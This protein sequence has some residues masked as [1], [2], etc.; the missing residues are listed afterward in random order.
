M[1]D[2]TD[3]SAVAKPIAKTPTMKPDDADVSKKESGAIKPIGLRKNKATY[4]DRFIA[5]DPIDW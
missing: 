2:K 1:K 5:N 4:P 3:I